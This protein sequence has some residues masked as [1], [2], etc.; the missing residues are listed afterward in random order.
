MWAQAKDGWCL[1]FCNTK[2]WCWKS[3]AGQISPISRDANGLLGPP[4][5][6]EKK[7]AEGENYIYMDTWT[8]VKGL[9]SDSGAWKEK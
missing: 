2:R 7:M 5:I 8:G 1:Y 3:K 4:H 9:A 6:G